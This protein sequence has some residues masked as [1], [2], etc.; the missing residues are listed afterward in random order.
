MIPTI[1]YAIT[2]YNEHD[3]L[4]R[5]LTQLEAHINSDDEIIV[6]LD[7][8]ATTEVRAVLEKF[9]SIAVTEFPLNKDFATFKNNIKKFCKKDY[10]VFIDADEVP[11]EYLISN[12]PSLLEQN[13]TVDM[14]LVPRINTVEGLTQDHI[15]KWGW[16]VDERGRVNFPDYQSRIMKNIPEIKWTGKVH[17]RLIG[18]STYAYLPAEDHWCLLHHKQIERQ[19]K[20]NKLYDTI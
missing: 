10:I 4:M 20:Q 2:A 9:Q 8:S 6:Q 19:E 5:L 15:A 7:T 16:R 11:N 12:L 14:F 3:E 1:S 13:P 17:E 18:T